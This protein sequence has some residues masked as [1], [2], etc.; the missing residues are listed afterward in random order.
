MDPI[1]VLVVDD[2]PLFAEALAVWLARQPGFEVVGAVQTV[3]AARELLAGAHVDVQLVDLDLGADSGVELLDHA[4]DRYPLLRSVIL[5]ASRSPEAVATAVRHGAVSWLSKTADGD[6]LLQVLRGVLR[7]ESWIPPELLAG[8]LR[9]LTEPA[10]SPVLDRLTV[11]E[12]QVLQCLVDGM[13]R[14]QIAELLFMSPNTVRTHTQNLLGKLPAHSALEAV[15]VALRCG[16]RPNDVGPRRAS[17][18]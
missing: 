3:A 1:R 11:R 13:T 15:S 8:L 17:A 6:T 2:Q 5:S 10:G 9:T 14:A 7:D 12:R 16:M 18:E 4:R